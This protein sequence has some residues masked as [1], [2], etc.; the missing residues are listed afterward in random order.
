M[1]FHNGESMIYMN[2]L[3]KNYY[4]PGEAYIIFQVGIDNFEI[5]HK[6]C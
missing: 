5:E 4:S 1:Y 6:T 2:C 3:S